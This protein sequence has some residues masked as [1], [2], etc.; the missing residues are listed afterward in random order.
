MSGV[1]FDRFTIALKEAGAFSP[2]GR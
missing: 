2:L 1:E